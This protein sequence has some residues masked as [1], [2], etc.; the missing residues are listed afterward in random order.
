MGV[1]ADKKNWS[2]KHVTGSMLRSV[3]AHCGVK[4]HIEL[5]SECKKNL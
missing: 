5:P 1:R 3:R 4:E 2:L